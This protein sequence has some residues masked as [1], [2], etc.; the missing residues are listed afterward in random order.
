MRDLQDMDI[1]HRVMLTV[2][3]VVAIIL[4]LAGI[5]YLSG[6]WEAQAQTQRARVLPPAPISKYEKRLLE[7]DRD[8]ADQAYR[9][10]I[11]HLFAIWMKDD[12]GQPLRA[13]TGAR[14]AR[15]AYERLTEAIEER[16]RMLKD[17]PP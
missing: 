1:G 17:H 13:A 6:R 11:Q 4:I 3:I 16:E 7:L 15:S 10:Q 5:G 9:E 2:A 12:S 8:A 14:Q